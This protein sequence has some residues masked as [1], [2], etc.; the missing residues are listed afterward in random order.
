[1]NP[2]R[3]RPRAAE[4][5]PFSFLRRAER[6]RVDEAVHFADEDRV[7]DFVF[8]IRVDVEMNA[9]VEAGRFVER[10]IVGFGERERLAERVAHAARCAEGA[11][12]GADDFLAV[13]HDFA[14]VVGDDDRAG[15]SRRP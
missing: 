7:Q 3:V 13:E 10:R 1:M 8:G 2:F 15:A 9:A 14:V 5:A 11:A 6:Q 4:L 12:G